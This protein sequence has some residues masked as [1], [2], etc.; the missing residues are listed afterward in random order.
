MYTALI[1]WW[2]NLCKKRKALKTLTNIFGGNE[3]TFFIVCNVVIYILAILF[4]YA[5]LF[6]H[7]TKP[8]IFFSSLLA[9]SI[10]IITGY[11]LFKGYKVIK[12]LG[13]IQPDDLTK[14]SLRRL[15]LMVTG[16]SLLFILLLICLFVIVGFSQSHVEGYIPCQVF[17]LIISILEFLLTM[18]AAYLLAGRP[19][20]FKQPSPSSSD[21][22]KEKTST[23]EKSITFTKE[24]EPIQNKI[25]EE[26]DEDEYDMEFDTTKVIVDLPEM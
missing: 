22:K 13:T 21:I 23:D 20:N 26:S 17:T 18:L 2:S 19:T 12:L 16:S 11:I 9:A 25:E 10:A 4:S 1:Q 8:I 5:P 24:K 15:T 6:F 7:N 3:K 14:T